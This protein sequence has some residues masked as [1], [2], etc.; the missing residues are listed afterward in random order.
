MSRVVQAG[1]VIGIFALSISLIPTLIGATTDDTKAAFELEE[2]EDVEVTDELRAEL[3][4]A[5]GTTYNAT[6]EYT[7]LDSLFTNQSKLNDSETDTVALEGENITTGLQS[8]T[9]G[10]AVFNTT[11]PA[12]YG[13]DTSAALIIAQ[14]DTLLAVIG[15]MMILGSVGVAIVI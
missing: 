7:D 15:I 14:M 3:T 1:I 12:T 5:N 4:K 2:G 10:S 11:Y 9:N 13:W 8:F 6:V